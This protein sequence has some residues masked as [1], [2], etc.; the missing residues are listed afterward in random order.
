M[1]LIFIL[2]SE[3]CIHTLPSS[4][5]RCATTLPDTAFGTAH[6][7]HSSNQTSRKHINP[8]KLFIDSCFVGNTNNIMNFASSTILFEI[9]FAIIL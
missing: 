1:N 4:F 9:Y 8:K 3:L 6:S 5:Y 7:T 2:H